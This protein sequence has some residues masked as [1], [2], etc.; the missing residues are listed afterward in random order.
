[1]YRIR[2]F[3]ID[4]QY[5][6]TN[7]EN[8]DFPLVKLVLEK[9]FIS[10]IREYNEAQKPY[11]KSKKNNTKNKNKKKYEITEEDIDNSYF[12]I[13]KEKKSIMKSLAIMR[14]QN[15]KIWVR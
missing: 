6:Y 12:K 10:L 7:K 3:T 2:V 15:R 14:L 13:K 1:M 9:L 11:K 5:D 8:I 4:I